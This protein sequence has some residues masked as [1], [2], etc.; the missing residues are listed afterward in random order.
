MKFYL[1]RDN[2]TLTGQSLFKNKMYTYIAT[3]SLDST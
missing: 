3:M 1:F 2:S